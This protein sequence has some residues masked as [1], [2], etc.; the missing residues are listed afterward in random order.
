[1]DVGALTNVGSG[2]NALVCAAILAGKGAKVLVLER[3]DRIGG[4]ILTEE[5]TAPGFIHD[6]M[7]TTFVLFTTGPAYA[8][9][10]KDLARHGLE[11]C[12]TDA[13]T[14]VLRPDG[15]YL[16]QRMDQAANI[17]GVAGDLLLAEAREA[18]A[19]AFHA[20]T[21]VCAAV[22]MLAGLVA[23][24]VLGRIKPDAEEKCEESSAEA[25][26]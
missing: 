19:S 11:F 26:A 5:I 24:L 14:G 17:G 22:S 8:V 2:I 12:N 15:S 6:V 4:C 25:A 10:A 16:I 20:V 23:L 18:Y 9:L 21:L 13:P 7:A 3:N 1:M